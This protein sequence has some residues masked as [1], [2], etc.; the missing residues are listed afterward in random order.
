[1]VF[2]NTPDILLFSS[3]HRLLLGEFHTSII[4]NKP[5]TSSRPDKIKFKTIEFEKKKQFHF[6][7][8]IYTWFRSS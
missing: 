3:N 2:N 6:V 7:S 1:M 4:Q 8:F 5:R